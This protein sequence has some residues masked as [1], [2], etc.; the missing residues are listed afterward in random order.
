MSYNLIL[1][2]MMLKSAPMGRLLF[3]TS[4]MFSFLLDLRVSSNFFSFLSSTISNLISLS[5]S[6]LKC[7][8][9]CSLGSPR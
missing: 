2:S 6:K 1:I 3:M 5:F 9:S 7:S 4:S 8:S